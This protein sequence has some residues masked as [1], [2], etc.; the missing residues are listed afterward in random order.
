[1]DSDTIVTIDIY[2]ININIKDDFIIKEPDELENNIIEVIENI[3][4]IEE[5]TKKDKENKE[6]KE[7]I[8]EQKVENIVENIEENKP[9]EIINPK[10][11]INRIKNKLSIEVPYK[12]K[13]TFFFGNR[14]KIYKLSI[15]FSVFQ[16]IFFLYFVYNIKNN[17]TT[18]A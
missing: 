16:A 13:K 6:N 10:E 7:N 8:E 3:K 15:L 14:N 11:I 2:N 17:L 1:M 4:E 12:T 18:T 9:I 5:E